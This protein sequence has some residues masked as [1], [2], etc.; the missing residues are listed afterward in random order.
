MEVFSLRYGS[1]Y[2][3]MVLYFLLHNALSIIYYVIM[4]YVRITSIYN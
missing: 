1:V 4:Y 2:V 3:H